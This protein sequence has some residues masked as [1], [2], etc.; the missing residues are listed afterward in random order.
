MERILG[1]LKEVG[2]QRNGKMK[3]AAWNIRGFNNPIK[4]VEVR[5]FIHANGLSLI[6]IT[7]TK[8]R[9]ENLNLTM[10]KCLPFGWDCVHNIGTGSVARIIVAWDTQ[11]PKV[12][13][14]ASSE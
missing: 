2:S 5:K 12:N 10:K 9:K 3:F 8:V 6:G 11:G 1:Q 7:E 13:V 14:L 4:Q